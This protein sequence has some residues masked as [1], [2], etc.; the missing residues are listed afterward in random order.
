L[1]IVTECAIFGLAI[2]LVYIGRVRLSA[3]V[4]ILL[5]FFTRILYVVL[6][7]IRCYYA[8]FNISVIIFTTLRIVYLPEYFHSLNPTYSGIPAAIYAL[9][10]ANSSVI[11]ATTPVLRSFILKFTYQAR[12]AV[13]PKPLFTYS[14]VRRPNQEKTLGSRKGSNLS[15]YETPTAA[16]SSGGEARPGSGDNPLS[17]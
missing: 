5:L 2:H 4:K 14:L 17:V 10:A 13:A 9:T 16:S 7:P 3:S 11:T 1:G 8:N 15:E 12:P 6:P